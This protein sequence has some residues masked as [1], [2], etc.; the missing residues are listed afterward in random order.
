METARNLKVIKRPRSKPL[1]DIP[2]NFPPLKNLHLELLEVKEKL[3]KGLPLIPISKPIIPKKE[4]SESSEEEK[5]GPIISPQ[6]AKVS[7]EDKSPE[8][9][10]PKDKKKKKE[11]KSKGKKKDAMVQELGESTTSDSSSSS[12]DSSSSSGSSSSSSSGSSK[13]SASET[14]ENNTEK[15]ATEAGSQNEKEEEKEAEYD[16]YAGLSPEEREIKEKEEYIWRFRILKKQYGRNP[17]INIPEWNEHSDLTLMK[18]SYERTIR[19]LYLDD[20]VETYRTYLFAG[21]M[22][23]EYV[24]TQMI[25]ID[26]RG[27]TLQQTKMMHKYDRMLIELGEKSYTRWGMN[28]PVEV[29]LFG[30][31]LFQAAIFYLGKVLYD[32]LGSNAAALFSSFTGQ[33]A[34]DAPQTTS[35]AT[36][37]N[38]ATSGNTATHQAAPP[39]TGA[40]MRGPRVSA[41]DIRNRKNEEEGS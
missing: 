14:S 8:E 34:P 2:I 32:K 37:S 16:P 11:K 18:T 13:S 27:F 31:I 24:C 17:A 1:L 25:Q 36:S 15:S 12:S 3:K 22:I 21:W 28:L 41:D 38:T 40:K 5:P 6:P 9:K 4:I 30:L 35:T 39:R 10:R 19:E 7:E 26:L 20:A 33:P 23:M 29:R